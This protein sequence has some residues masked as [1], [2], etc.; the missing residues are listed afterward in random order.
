MMARL[1]ACIAALVLVSPVL[2]GAQSA[3]PPPQQDSTRQRDLVLDPPDPK[4]AK[5]RTSVPRGY[6]LVI[7]V[8]AYQNL[9]ASKQLRFAET[10][11]QSIYRVLISHEG[12]AFP[13]ENVHVLLG[14]QATLANIR[15]EL[16]VW[17]PSVAQPS[18]RVVVFFAGHGFVKNQKGYLAA[19][20]VDPNKLETTAYP[21]ATLGDVLGRR[22][23]ARWK[24][25]LTDACHS[26]KINA[27]TT[28]EA[29]EQQFNSLPT[30]FL[31]LTATTEREQSY[32]FPQLSTGFGLFTYFLGQAW[33]GHADNDPC[34]GVITADEL[35]EYV[36]TNVRRYAKDRQL[37]QTPTARGDYDPTMT[38]GVSP[39]C[40]ARDD[41]KAPSML[42]TAIV[43]VNL[44]GVDLYVD[45]DLVGKITK[46]K[47]LVIPRLSS[48]LHEFKGVKEGY[49][50][51]RKQIM[52]APGQEATV[53]LRIR[54]VRQIKPS[55]LN[56]VSEGERLLFTQ[57]SSVN[58][59]NVL[60]VAR[61]QS[62]ADLRKARD[63]FTAALADDPNYSRAAFDLGQVNQL[64]ANDDGSL[65][66]YKQAIAI[67]PSYVDA[68]AQYAAVLIESGDPDQGI[69]ELTEALRLD[70]KNDEL[71][72]MMARAYWDK[73]VW[74]RAVESAEKAVQL[75]PS[76]AQALLW[77]ADAR[78]Q[79]AATEKRPEQQA[80]LYRE[81]RSDYRAFLNLTNFSSSFLERLAFHAIGSGVGSRRHADRQDPYNGLR[82]AGYLGLC[83]TE[84]K[85]GNALRAREYCQRAL[86]Y[87]PNDPITYFVL[88]NVN[89]D[90]YNQY[91]S[92]EYL[93]AAARNY[94]KMVTLNPSLD[95]SKN[96][97]NYLEQITGILPK[98]RCS[99]G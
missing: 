46:G 86:R 92:C 17:L 69:R 99:G 89:R 32:E 52:I 53:T 15:H 75:N 90:L 74:A 20:D 14:P 1:F 6:A 55:A 29:L 7:G 68:R 57:R 51:D 50:P 70:P 8:S 27:E 88:G 24:V 2:E 91:E 62:E 11:A 40:L 73:G 82:K 21:M 61:A 84:Q 19:S 31:T 98:L 23:K 59:L 56:L 83:L 97:R 39:G 85:V 95:E 96:A 35:I 26:G 79:L 18:D 63:L 65:Q 72:S 25:L 64:L 93:I 76:N 94:D 54:Y 5:D 60:P 67:D 36:R 37:S 33:K 28:N 42:G 78:R 71:H 12:G 4:P 81:A 49:E 80:N 77:R 10:D 13:A 16:E 22:V 30:S 66:A 9:D 34:D 43:E 41:P 44:D 87:A 47:P 38:L 45:G 48:G 58:P 3:T